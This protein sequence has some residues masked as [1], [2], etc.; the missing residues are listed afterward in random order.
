MP[1]DCHALLITFVA[2]HFFSLTHFAHFFDR[3]FVETLAP[4]I[5]HFFEKD[6]I[7]SHLESQ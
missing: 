3:E 7:S 4:Q 1:V 5:L 6:F 2:S